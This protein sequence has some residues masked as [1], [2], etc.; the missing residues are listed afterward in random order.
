MRKTIVLLLATALFACQSPLKEKYTLR[1]EVEGQIAGLAYL[2]DRVSG[3]MVDLDSARIYNGVFTFE[4]TM[5]SPQMYYVRIDGV[6]GRIAV[7]MENSEIQL[8]ITQREPLVYTVEGSKSHDIFTQL[9]DLVAPYDERSRYV[10]SELGEAEKA[11]NAEAIAE[12][13]KMSD[14][15]RERK[16][17][18]VLSFIRE[19]PDMAVSVFIAQRQLSHGASPEEL[20]KI[21]AVFDTSLQG[22]RY[23]DEME[24]NLNTLRR[25]ATGNPAIDFTLNNTEGE[26]ISLS[27]FQ[28][29]VVLISFWASWCPYCR[30]SNPE[31]VRI[32][33]K[34]GGEGFE[35]LG[36]SLDRTHEAWVRGIEE[37]GLKWPQVSDLQGWQSGPAAEYAVRS[38][39]QN[40]LVDQNGI[41]IGR[42]LDYYD[43]EEKLP[44][45]LA[46]V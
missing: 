3:Q 41:I 40:V 36:V 9:G 19:Y 25:V 7:F 35:V 27:N 15:L 26:S 39:P 29:Q 20:E 28:G 17:E 2:Q 44:L 34:F 43:L 14:E 11:G 4:G 30:D 6:P 1:G 24:K 42:N 16:K 12:F 8:N 31:L 13:R 37:D 33:E 23:Y 32:Y 45:L 46:G 38:I 18:E 10:Q 5:D 21:F 22:T